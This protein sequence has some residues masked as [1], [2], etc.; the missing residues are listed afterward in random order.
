MLVHRLKLCATIIFFIF[1]ALLDVLPQSESSSLSNAD[2]EAQTCL[3]QEEDRKVLGLERYR[4]KKKKTRSAPKL[5]P[6]LRF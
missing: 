3:L 2:P 6:N 4:D 5:T 1:E